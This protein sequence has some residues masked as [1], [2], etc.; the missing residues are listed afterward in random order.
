MFVTWLQPGEAGPDGQNKPDWTSRCNITNQKDPKGLYSGETNKS[1]SHVNKCEQY[2][3]NQ[4]LK[5]SKSNVMGGGWR[6]VKSCESH[7]VAE[8]P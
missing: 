8:L 3:C 5:A 6:T 2:T 4:I 7:I 1:K